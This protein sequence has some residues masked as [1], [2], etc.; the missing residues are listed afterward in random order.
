MAKNK[1]KKKFGKALKSTLRGARKNRSNK[2]IYAVAG[3]LALILI[4]AI[5]LTYMGDKKPM[6]KEKLILESVDYLENVAY[7]K[8][9]KVVPEDNKI[10][11]VFDIQTITGISR[12]VDLKKI[13]RYAG[14]RIS[15]ELKGE[16]V[17]VLLTEIKKKEKDYLI[18]IKNG[19]VIGEQ[20]LE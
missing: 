12:N 15:H 2:L 20:E 14:V 4:I 13:A 16:E 1:K 19:A 8:E 9:L 5:M 3:G 18:T 11:L 10:I 7:I 6:D 17:K